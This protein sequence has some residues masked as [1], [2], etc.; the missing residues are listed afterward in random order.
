MRH[1]IPAS[2]RF[3]HALRPLLVPGLRNSQYAYGDELVRQSAA[4]R[5]WLDIGCGHGVVPE[6]LDHP[7]RRLTP[8][9]G[10]DLDLEA[11]RRNTGV[12]W[13]AMA[14]GEALPFRAASFDLISANMVVEHVVTPESLFEEVGRVLRPGGTFV[15]HTP[16]VHGYTTVLTRLIPAR[17]RAMLA[18]RL[19][20]RAVE[21]VYPTH[22]R[23][24]SV[25]R[26]G[27]LADRAGL[28]IGDMRLVL[29]SPQLVSIPPL[30]VP[31]LLVI[32]ALSS[33][34]LSRWR[35]C[36]L[37]VLQKRG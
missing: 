32:R 21:D 24:N 37:A 20:D 13:R 35:P 10:V 12:R 4:A 19:H 11:L 25:S 22:Y 15:L 29:T 33:G 5:A 17:L 1:S 3:Y 36:L 7:A 26:V 27:S 2:E 23:A 34:A 16:N 30:L 31:E 18:S 8:H 14:S 28:R 6:W 9:V